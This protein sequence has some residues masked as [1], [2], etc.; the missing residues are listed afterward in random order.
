[1]DEDDFSRLPDKNVVENETELK[2]IVPWN[3]M[4][5]YVKNYMSTGY[6][7]I[8]IYLESQWKFINSG[9]GS[10]IPGPQG[11]Q[12]PKGDKGDQGPKGEDA[13][14]PELSKVAV[15]GRYEDLLDRPIIPEKYDDSTLL[16]KIST[17]ETTIANILKRLNILEG[18]NNDGSDDDVVPSTKEYIEF[19]LPS[20]IG[21]INIKNKIEQSGLS[22]VDE[23]VLGPE[24]D[25]R[26]R[27]YELR[28]WGIKNNMLSE[29]QIVP[30]V[31]DSFN[32]PTR[33]GQ[34][35]YED[36]L[37]T[38]NAGVPGDAIFRFHKIS[39]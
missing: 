31:Y 32:A 16:S 17:L 10:G 18:N 24:F 20:V 1:M 39:N 5:V 37:V 33:H 23:D 34:Y 25:G 27:K 13:V 14:L 19:L 28:Y 30:S 8:A 2:K 12:G 7:C 26:N 22:M 15:T 11:P 6:P 36:G 9:S 35:D 21:S 4:I 29:G 38:F 3:E